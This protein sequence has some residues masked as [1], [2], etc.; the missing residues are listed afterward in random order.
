MKALRF[1]GK[2]ILPT[3]LLIMV[4]LLV[5]LVFAITQFTDFTDYLVEDRV[6]TAANGVREFAEDIRRYVIDVG[7]Q[8]SQDQ[9]LINAILSD[10]PAEVLRV[11]NILVAEY[12]VTYITVADANATVLTRTDEPAQYGDQVRTA[13]LLEA[14]EG[15]I[16]V[17][18]GPVGLRQLPLRSSVPVFHQGEIIGLVVVAY[19][20]DTD[21]AVDALQS[22][23][24]AEFIIYVGDTAVASTF[25]RPDGSRALGDTILQEA[26]DTV[27]VREQEL[28][29]TVREAGADFSAFYLPLRDPYGNIYATIFMGLPLA[30]I[31]SQQNFVIIAVVAIGAGGLALAMVIMF[32]IAGKLTKPIKQLAVM[33]SDVSQGN[34]N[35][36]K[37][38]KISQDEIG[39]LTKDVYDLVDVIRGIINDVVDFHRQ[40]ITEGD[41]EINLD[42]QKYQGAYHELTA[43]IQ[44]MYE[45]CERESWS[46]M[47]ILDSVGKGKFDVSMEPFPGKRAVINEIVDKVLANLKGVSTEVGVMVNAA[48]VKGELSYKI[49][50]DKY[51]GDWQDIMKGLNDI[52]VAVDAPIGEIKT[53]MT[54]LGDD[55]RLD[56]RIEGNYAGDFL[57]IKNTVNGTMGTL[58]NI[59]SD[60][61]RTLA[62]VSTGDLTTQVKDN[63]PGDF[64]A[65]RE[66]INNICGTLSRT[67]SDIAMAS[68]QVLTG[69]RQISSSAMDLA[70]GASEQA[71]SVEE[72]NASV[73]IISEKTR[74]NANNASEANTISSRSTENAKKGNDAMGQMLDAMEGIKNSSGNISRIIKVIQDIAF[75]TNL[76][77]LNASVEAARAGEHGRGFAV[78][79]EEVGNLA[80]RSQE[81]AKET[82]GLIEDS[83]NRVDTGSGIAQ[84][85]AQ[86]LDVIVGNASDVLAII[87]RISI[88]SQEQ[89]EAVG[90]VGIGLGQI[91]TVVQS[92]SAVSEETAAAAQELNSQAE[93]LKQLVSFFKV[94]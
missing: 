86:A 84:S 76:L 8:V 93:T 6:Q 35:I 20:L 1:K 77:A 53:V 78:V 47:D 68:D 9:R 52:A 69:A 21:K 41:Y 38:D 61:S 13:S 28:F 55:G 36:N 82:T 58:S 34:L 60:V 81:A 49:E 14:L 10:T 33:V 30:E 4:L 15:V 24:G 75:Q 54:R 27:L 73:D 63:Y 3:A 12:G 43:A 92:N 11:G 85:T 66:S 62:A 57:A 48:V 79:A 42:T 74:Q 39:E 46:M 67:M 25:R 70:N 5:T 51:Q 44:H 72:L 22:Q 31:N 19:A 94:R 16:S 45:G 90:Q 29:A 2:I 88:S 56:K 83:V 18:Y 7:L 59:I 17:A 65:I 37:N 80:A 64:A 50:V 32:F 89:S 91:S 71:S 26:V 23:F 87:N 40:A